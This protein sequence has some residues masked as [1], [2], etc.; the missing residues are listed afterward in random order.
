M[1]AYGFAAVRQSLYQ[2]VDRSIGQPIASIHFRRM[3]CKYL[4]EILVWRFYNIKFHQGQ[5]RAIFD[6]VLPLRHGKIRII[7]ISV[8]FFF[9][10]VHLLIW[11]LVYRI[12]LIILRSSFILRSSNFY[13]VTSLG[14]WK[15]LIIF[16]FCSF[17]LQI[18]PREGTINVSQR[19]LVL[20]CFVYLIYI[21]PFI[22]QVMKEPRM[23]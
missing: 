18:F 13:R 6:R 19:F 3:G 10:E 21:L 14:L 23:Y 15:I 12:I 22:C 8:H 4:N 2:S 16:S 17:S 9:T 20:N 5:N 7:A 1:R 11:N